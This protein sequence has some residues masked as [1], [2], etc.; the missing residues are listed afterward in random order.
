MTIHA[1]VI[2]GCVALAALA[3]PGCKADLAVDNPNV[4]DAGT[5]DPKDAAAVDAFGLS[6]I[7]NL[8]RADGYLATYSGWFVGEAYVSETFPTRNEF[9]RRDI[10]GLTNG[11]LLSDVWQPLSVARASGDK[12]LQILK[13]AP[14]ASS[15]INAARG[16][17]ASGYAMLWMAQEFCQG[18]IDAGPPLTPAA[19]ADTA[20][21]RFG[22]AISVGKAAA[23]RTTY[24]SAIRAEGT[25]LANAALVGRAAAYLQRGNKTAALADAQA[26]PAGFEYDLQYV[27]D[28]TNRE[29]LSNRQ[30][31]FT[32]SRASLSVAPSWRVNDPRVPYAPGASMGIFPQDGGLP[33][34]TDFYAQTKWT[35]FAAP[36]RLAS[37]LEADYIAAEAQG[38]AAELAL[39][40][41]RRT[42][43]KQPAYAGPTDDASVLTELLTQKGFDF[44]LENKR[45]GDFTRDP[46]NVAF[47]PPT[48]SA[49]EKPGYD[50]IGKQTCFPLPAQE[51]DNNPNFHS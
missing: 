16:A 14:D 46:A 21:A 38:N 27:D 50:P 4:V 12:I 49:Y 20:I 18:D 40:N 10:S 1:R 32:L 29:R 6:A 19:M 33:S 26:V 41:A 8:A 11:S 36:I 51:T 42:V 2:A 30:W 47:V 35:S 28:L 17:L 23:A 22:T 48:G 43:A 37:R 13:D 24:S 44:Y 25:A 39:I 3:L 9:G 31:Q 5:V 7:T 15:N 34:G 45:L